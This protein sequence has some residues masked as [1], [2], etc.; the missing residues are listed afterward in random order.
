MSDSFCVSWTIIFTNSHI[1]GIYNF[2]YEGGLQYLRHSCTSIA[3]ITNLNV[4]LYLVS[5]NIFELFI[6]Y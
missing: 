3:R 4:S 5:I 6:N 1:S 2:A